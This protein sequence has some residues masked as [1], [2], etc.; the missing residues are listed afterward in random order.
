MPDEGDQ[1][2]PASLVV[3]LAGPRP[4]ALAEVR[5]QAVDF[6]PPL[7]DDKVNDVLLVVT[8]LV[9]NAYDHGERALALRVT[10]GRQVIRVE[11][12]DVSPRLPTLGR[13][14][15][16]RYRGHGLLMV[17]NLC[18]DWGVAQRDGHKTVWAVLIGD[19]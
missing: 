6:L 8:E 11:V 2:P 15:I 10:C 18:K 1:P 14:S 17:E 9:S 16:G 7:S 19:Y 3:A 4:P 5:R 12:D 13:S